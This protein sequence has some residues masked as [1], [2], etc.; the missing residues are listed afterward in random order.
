MRLD[1]APSPQMCR[2]L[3][4]SGDL[5]TT[6]PVGRPV[7][8]SILAWLFPA[9]AWAGDSASVNFSRDILPIFSQNCF[10]CHGPDAVGFDPKKPW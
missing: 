8:A 5:A 7:F 9:S 10:L 3:A 4:R 1:H 2:R 6:G